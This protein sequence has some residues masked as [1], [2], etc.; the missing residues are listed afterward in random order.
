VL[1]RRKAR[2][3]KLRNNHTIHKKQAILSAI[4]PSVSD[5]FN[6]HGGFDSICLDVF[7]YQSAHNPTYGAFIR[8]LGIDP[9]GVHTPDAIPYLPVELFKTHQILSGTKE[10]EIIF[11][12]SG[13]SGT[14][15]SRHAVSDLRVYRQ[16]F[17]QAFELFYGPVNQYCIIALLP[18]YLERE[19]SSL[20]LMADD[21]IL[22]SGHP[23]SGFCLHDIT[24]LHER[25]LRL[26]AAS[27]KTI[28]LGV[29]YALLDLA[30]AFE[31]KL[32]H[33]LVME[34][35]GMK[36]MRK[37]LV[38]EELHGYLCK[39]LGVDTVHSEYGMTELLSQGYSSGKGIFR[40]PPWMKINVR[41]ANDPLS[42]AKAGAT[43]G[44]NVIDLA[45]VNS[46][47]FIATQDL[48]KV[49]LDGSFEVLG[50]FD[51]SDVRGCNLL[52]G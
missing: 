23:E 39:R 27:Q 38:R 13:T 44:I 30:D 4:L 6:L 8:G 41:D 1:L 47:S 15:Q 43:G 12:S 32:K 22:R 40:T 20:V 51:N 29:T 46:C 3:I 31:M 7:K 35:G 21:L 28:L 49:Y 50:R 17:R 42:P 25:L 14:L 10:P 9:D 52:I 11:S 16:S 37:E 18:S 26:E 19:G 34:T 5:I 2:A 48:G 24:E 36:G 45:N 33:T